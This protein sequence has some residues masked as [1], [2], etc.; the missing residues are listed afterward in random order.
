M[1]YFI[2]DESRSTIVVEK[3]SKLHGFKF[4]GDN[5]DK[6]IHPRFQ[7]HEKRGQSLHYF[8]GYA[9]RDR[10]DLSTLSDVT[11]P[12]HKPDPATFLPSK[13]DISC[14]SDELTVLVS[15]LVN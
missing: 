8:H 2:Q 3:N 5:I 9:V 15:R 10:I 11:P 14:L 1:H 13:N 6:N 12:F 4:V 7:R